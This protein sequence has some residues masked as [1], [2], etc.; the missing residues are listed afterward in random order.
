M[1]PLFNTFFIAT[2]TIYVAVC[3]ATSRADA[4]EWRF[5]VS[6]D[7]KPIGYHHFR[8][9]EDGTQRELKSDARFDVKF[10]FFNAYRYEH[11][12]R[13]V[14]RDDCV[15][16]IAAH[17]DVNGVRKVVN[18]AQDA[19][20]FR[21][22]TEERSANLEHCV[23]TFA[24]WN[25]RILSASRLLNPQTGEYV[26]VKVS[27][28][29]TDTIAVRGRQQSAVHYRIESEPTAAEPLAIDLWYSSANEWLALKSLTEGGR[30]LEYRLQ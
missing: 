22:N 30:H 24:Y 15:T 7:G 27:R 21:L 29:G 16:Q 10:L 6:L 14:W 2:A 17:T 4:E 3:G 23:M 12:D 13:E 9:Q 19:E 1:K 28:V 5:A 20:Q 11:H 8:L 18:G 26:P 25:P